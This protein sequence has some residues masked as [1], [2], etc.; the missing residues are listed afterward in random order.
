MQ[1][2]LGDLAGKTVAY[3]GDYN[4]VAR[5][6]AEVSAM[7]GMHIRFA[8]PHGFDAPLPELERFAL[9]GA[10]SVEQSSRPAEAVAGAHA[11]H[12]D[13]WVSMCQESEKQ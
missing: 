12:P 1:Q 7:L 6:L 3:V 11:V 2:Q 8:C 5:S 10:V 13:T 9:L 4:N